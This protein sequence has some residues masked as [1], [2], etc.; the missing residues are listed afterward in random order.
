MVRLS[1][2]CV[3]AFIKFKMMNR[4]KLKPVNRSKFNA[5]N[6]HYVLFKN[7]FYE[8]NYIFYSRITY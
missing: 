1:V 2:G 8:K 4:S 5:T 3:L 7:L 6:Y